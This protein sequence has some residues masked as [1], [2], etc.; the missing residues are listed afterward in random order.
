MTE[1]ELKAR[2]WKSL[3]DYKN[4]LKAA[5]AV[6]SRQSNRWAQ[7]AI[8]AVKSGDLEEAQRA[9]SRAQSE[10]NTAARCQADYLKAGVK[11][12]V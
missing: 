7:E 9:L 10:A 12:N 8:R 2:G 11:E 6:A 5:L 4:F 3:D 1:K